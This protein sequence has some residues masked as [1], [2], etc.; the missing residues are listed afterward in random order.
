MPLSD[1]SGWKE[2]SQWARTNCEIN[3]GRSSSFPRRDPWRRLE[4]RLSSRSGQAGTHPIQRDYRRM[5]QD[6]FKRCKQSWW[7]RPERAARL[8]KSPESQSSYSIRPLPEVAS[9]AIALETTQAIEHDGVFSLATWCFRVAPP[10]VVTS[11]SD[12]AGVEFI[13]VSSSVREGYDG[14]EILRS[15]GR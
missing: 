2:L 1:S 8:P 13:S 6:E 14:P 5:H 15:S 7:R 10:D 12:D 9:K 4:V 3:S 11:I